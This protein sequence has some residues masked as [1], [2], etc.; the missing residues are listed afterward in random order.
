LLT[1]CGPEKNTIQFAADGINFEP[2]ATIID[3][4]QAAGALRVAEAEN[5][6]PL[7]GLRWG[8]SHVTQWSPHAAQQGRDALGIATI[9]EPWD[10]LIRWESHD[11]ALGW[12]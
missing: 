10:F 2:R 1:R 7:S 3:P 6:E 8:L 5:T 11:Q 4:P 9:D 12:V